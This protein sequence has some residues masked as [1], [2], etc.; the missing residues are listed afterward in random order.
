MKRIK[1]QTSVGKMGEFVT[2][3]FL[4]T[5]GYECTDPDCEVYTGRNKSWASDLFVNEHKIAVKTQ[6]LDSA[7][8]FGKSWIFQKGG[9][10][11]GHVDPIIH[12]GKSFAVFVT[13]DLNEKSASVQGPFNMKDLRPHFKEPKVPSLRFSK[14]ALY[15]DDIKDIETVS[16]K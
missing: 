12:G 6:D 7:L 10:G 8:R 14:L 13:L 15:W 3:E 11:F 2:Q 5:L 1:H 4:S 16:I 9:Y